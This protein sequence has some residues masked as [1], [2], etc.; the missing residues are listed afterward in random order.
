[1]SSEEAEQYA[2]MIFDYPVKIIHDAAI[3]DD[4]GQTVV[5]VDG[6]T[7]PVFDVEV[8]AHDELGHTLKATP[9]DFK[10]WAELAEAWWAKR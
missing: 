5:H 8:E 1:M 6:L 4:D 9:A 3:E 2:A 10:R 7:A